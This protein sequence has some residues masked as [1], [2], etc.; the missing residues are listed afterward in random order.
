MA[1]PYF[2]TQALGHWFIRLRLLIDQT[3]GRFAI[4]A[5]LASIN[6]SNHFKGSQSFPEYEILVDSEKALCGAFEEL[7]SVLCDDS[8]TDVADGQRDNPEDWEPHFVIP[9]HVK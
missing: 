7:V 1:K 2:R 8:V 5:F 9:F 3:F 6:R 4:A